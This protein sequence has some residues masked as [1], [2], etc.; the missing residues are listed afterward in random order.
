MRHSGVTMAHSFRPTIEHPHSGKPRE[1][2][3]REVGKLPS[4]VTGDCHAER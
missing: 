3:L 1:Q 4:P 2:P